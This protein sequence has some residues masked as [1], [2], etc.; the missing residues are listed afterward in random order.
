MNNIT[1]IGSGTMGFSILELL[2]NNNIDVL[3]LVYNRE[4]SYKENYDIFYKRIELLVKKKRYDEKILNG[5]KQIN[6]TNQYACIS[7]SDL[8][9]EAVTEDYNEKH[10]LYSN[11]K[12]YINEDSLVTTNTSS[13]S[14][15]ALANLIPI[16][17]KFA[18]FHFFNPA[19][20]M[21]L[22][23]IIKGLNTTQ[24]TIDELFKFA[25]SLN[26]KP[27]IINEGPGFIVN[28]MLIP[29]I[30]EAV[31]ILGEGVA[32]KEDIDKAM[33]Y[34]ANHPMGPLRLADYIGNDVV[35]SIMNT[36]HEE[37]GDPKYRVHTLLRKMVRANKLGKKTKEGFYRY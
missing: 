27:V 6:F 14:I 20:R 26:K 34:G 13:L 37:T 18:G 30:N 16:K 17:H 3:N 23:E 9:I 19:P 33:V 32:S 1:I 35:L 24:E 8:V 28:R 4:S 12:G 11:I 29:M 5:L 25:K 36:L 15:T 21:D 10:K 2:L 7:N 22:V 31:T